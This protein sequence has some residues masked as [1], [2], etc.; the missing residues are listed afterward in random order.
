MV[1]LHSLLRWVVLLTAVAA[2]AGFAMVRG[3]GSW[4]DLT[5]WMTRSYVIAITL[6]V[7]LGMTL[8]ATQLRML[9][10]GDRF[11]SIEHPL[12]MLVATGVVHV[13]FARA[14]KRE[15]A[16]RGATVGL[17]AALLSLLLVVAAIPTSA[18]GL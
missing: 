17:T 16:R 6:Q 14:W 15:D 11:F 18:W 9:G 8:W 10:G 2:L 5:R 3:R 4:D 7:L 12:M 1:E 13:G